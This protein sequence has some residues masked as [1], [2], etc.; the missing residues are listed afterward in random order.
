MNLRRSG[1]RNVKMWMGESLQKTPAT[2][3]KAKFRAG[4]SK[5]TVSV[6]VHYNVKKSFRQAKLF[7][8]VLGRVPSPF[9][10]SLKH[11]HLIPGKVHPSH[12]SV[13]LESAG[14]VGEESCGAWGHFKTG[15]V[16]LCVEDGLQKF[17]EET[18]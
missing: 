18:C 8:E 7:A 15:T 6:A 14:K 2:I 12:A 10:K 16:T 1:Q 17:K 13:T 4:K 3:F 9:R 11:L 5:Q